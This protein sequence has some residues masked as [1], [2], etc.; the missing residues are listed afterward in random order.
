M[1]IDVCERSTSPRRVDM[2]I[3]FIQFFQKV[4][5]LGDRFRRIMLQCSCL[6]LLQHLSVSAFSG[7]L[8]P[9]FWN[10]IRSLANSIV[11]TP[12]IS[13]KITSVHDGFCWMKDVDSL[14]DSHSSVT[15]KFLLNSSF[16]LVE[17]SG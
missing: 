15:P 3:P 17:A 2:L 7:L 13:P 11:E 10:V 4:A 1:C 6:D 9:H 16:T 12:S 8:H 5:S 14:A